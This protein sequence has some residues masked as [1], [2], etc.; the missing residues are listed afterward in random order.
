[1]KLGGGYRDLKVMHIPPSTFCNSTKKTISSKQ[2]VGQVG[3][4]YIFHSSYIF[5]SDWFTICHHM[6]HAK[7]KLRKF[8]I[9]H[10]KGPANLEQYFVMLN[11]SNF[12]FV[13]Y[14][15]PWRRLSLAEVCL[16]NK[17][18]AACLQCVPCTVACLLCKIQKCPTF[19]SNFRDTLTEAGMF[20]HTYT[21]YRS[22]RRTAS[23]EFKREE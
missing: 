14:K 11:L 15:S 6:S 12:S 13:T 22:T 9:K 21:Y 23:F 8:H 18:Y 10:R 2:H 17:A 5:W 16:R 1:M 7:Q 19:R 20:I 3:G 4:I